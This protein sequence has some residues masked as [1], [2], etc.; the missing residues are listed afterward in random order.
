MVR[1]AGLS[2]QC[3]EKKPDRG[4]NVAMALLRYESLSLLIFKM[5]DKREHELTRTSQM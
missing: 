4:L 5:W 2:V 3:K 1:R